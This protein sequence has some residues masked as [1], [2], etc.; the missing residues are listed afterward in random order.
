MR[1][2]E[3]A[4]LVGVPAEV[5]ATSRAADFYTLT[6]ARIGLMAALAA[7]AGYLVATPIAASPLTLAALVVGV[8]LAAAGSSA[9]NMVWERRLDA[10]MQRT[11]TRPLAAGRLGVREATAFG[12]ALVAGGGALLW[13]G[14]SGLAALVALGSFAGY[15]FCYTPLKTRTSLNT[16]V[17][18]IPGAL[19]P[20]VGWAAATGSLPGEA[21]ALFALLFLWQIPHFLAIAWLYR[22]DYERAGM[23]MLPVLD[24]EGW[25]TGRQMVLYAVALIPISLAPRCGCG[26]T[27]S[28]MPAR[29][30]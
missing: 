16:V 14:A 8:W 2:A 19:P 17:G 6:K 27:Q 30:S 3:L 29:C 23:P 28:T 15:L 20:L 9:L 13:L 4:S 25:M 26:T 24:R 18:A 21:W 1:E 11:S 5:T 22:A 12:A 10:R 7:A